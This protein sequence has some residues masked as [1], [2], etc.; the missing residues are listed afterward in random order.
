MEKIKYDALK[1]AE[2]EFRSDVL[3]ITVY[4][5]LPRRKAAKLEEVREI[6]IAAR[7]RNNKGDNGNVDV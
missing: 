5:P 2:K 3:P 7:N 4:R 6:M 1:I